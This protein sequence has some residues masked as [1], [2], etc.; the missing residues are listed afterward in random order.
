MLVE[1]M[2]LVLNKME[3][4]LTDEDR[5]MQRPLGNGTYTKEKLATIKCP[6]CENVCEVSCATSRGLIPSC[7]EHSGRVWRN[8]KNLQKSKDGSWEVIN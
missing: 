3:Q 5:A 1:I 2:A 8:L 7:R 4:Y 6:F